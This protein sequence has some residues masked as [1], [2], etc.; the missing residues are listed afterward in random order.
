[1]PVNEYDEFRQT[2]EPDS[3]LAKWL[4]GDFGEEMRALG[5]TRQQGQ[6]TLMLTMLILN[7]DSESQFQ[8]EVTAFR[9]AF[10][11]FRVEGAWKKD[12]S[13]V[14]TELAWG[15]GPVY[16]TVEPDPAWDGVIPQILNPDF[17]PEQGT[18]QFIDDPNFVVPT[19]LVDRVDPVV[20]G[21]SGT[22]VFESSDQLVNYFPGGVVRDV[23]SPGGWAPK[24]FA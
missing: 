15:D 11:G 8:A 4:G 18:P 5:L 20:T 1:M 9:Q 19:V 3:L 14:G 23:F 17:D 24:V 13:Q 7:F 10:P 2:P 12:G 22:P 6:T 16:Q 21:L